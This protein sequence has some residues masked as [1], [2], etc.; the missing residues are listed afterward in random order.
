MKK[1]AI[2]IGIILIIGLAL[3]VLA[4]RL[5]GYLTAPKAQFVQ[6]SQHAVFDEY[7]LT[8]VMGYSEF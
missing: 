4:S 6:Q 2:K 3:C 8:G 1:T 5:I 7:Y